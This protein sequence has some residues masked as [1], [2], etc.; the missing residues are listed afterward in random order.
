MSQYAFI[1]LNRVSEITETFGIADPSTWKF[2]KDGVQ[3]GGVE[4]VIF[5]TQQKAQIENLGGQWFEDK[6]SFCAWLESHSDPLLEV[7]ADRQFGQQ[8]LNEFLAE[9]KTMNLTTNQSLGLL[10][11]LG[12]VKA[13]LEAGALTA[14]KEVLN[15]V[16]TDAIFTAERKANFLAKLTDY[17]A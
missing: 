4:E 16:E 15:S 8:L 7:I 1:P 11:K 2:E 3:Y 12:T 17:L 6:T 13:L 5:T 9:N 10:A 14:A